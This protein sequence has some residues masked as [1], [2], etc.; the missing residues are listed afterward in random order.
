M[1]VEVILYDQNGSQVSDTPYQVLGDRWRLE[2]NILAFKPWMNL[3]GIHS[4]YKVTG[5]SGEFENRTLE[6]YAYNDPM[7]HNNDGEFK[8]AMEINGGTGDFFKTVYKQ[9][10]SSPFIDSAYG[11]EVVEPADGMT[12]TIYASQ[13]ALKAKVEN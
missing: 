1:I 13:D 11:N 9:A 7:F 12:Y 8:K 3:V 2:G 4:G 5:L 10:W 6:N